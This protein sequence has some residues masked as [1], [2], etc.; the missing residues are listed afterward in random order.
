MAFSGQQPALERPGH[1]VAINS[2]NVAD[3][4]VKLALLHCHRL[5]YPLSFGG[6]H[7][8]IDWTLADWCGQCHRKGG[9]V[10]WSDCEYLDWLEH[11]NPIAGEPLADVVLGK[12]DAL[13]VDNVDWCNQGFA[14]WYALLGGGFRIPLMGAS[15]KS[16]NGASLGP[17]ADVRLAAP[18][19]G[20]ELRALDRGRACRADVREQWP[21]LAV[22][23]QRQGTGEHRGFAGGHG[24]H[25][26]AFGGPQPRPGG[27]PGADPGRRSGGG[28]A[29]DRRSRHGPARRG[30]SGPRV[31]LVAL[32]CWG[33][34]TPNKAIVLTRRPSMFKWRAKR[35]R[36]SQTTGR[37]CGDASSTWPHASIR[38]AASPRTG[39]VSVWRPFTSRQSN[40]WDLSHDP[41]RDLRHDASRRQPGR[42]RQLLA[43]GQAAHHAPA[44]RARRRL[45]RG[46]LSAFQSQGLR[47]FPG[48]PQAAAEARAGLPPSA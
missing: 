32:R 23:H 10:V 33:R 48:S 41:H 21:A 3:E 43:A 19:A 38:K 15:G 11:D 28:Q 26:G 14:D 30:V 45:H 4:A 34:Q 39:T 25:P 37:Y 46:R 20:A 40:C 29:H 2:Q 5:V 42:R 47:V 36:P 17:G 7:A 13:E 9:L 12:I 1:L 27:A 8:L 16:S 6:K 31:G 44:R 22:F 24:D 18:G 35:R